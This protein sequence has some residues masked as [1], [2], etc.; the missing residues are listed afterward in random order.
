[1]N[2][3]RKEIYSVE[4]ILS[5]VIPS[6]LKIKDSTSLI[7]FDDDLINMTSQRYQ[8]FKNKGIRCVVCGIKGKYFAKEKAGNSKRFHFNLYAIDIYGNEVMMTKDHIMR[9]REGGKDI[10][11]N[12]QPMCYRCNKR[13]N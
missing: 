8:V 7:E 4:K 5:N 9:R 13:K 3:T 2:Y 1:M 11:E 6:P 12:Y 10:L